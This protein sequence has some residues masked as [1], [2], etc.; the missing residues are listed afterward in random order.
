M[1]RHLLTLF[2]AAAALLVLAGCGALLLN[3]V[4]SEPR[5]VRVV[6]D[7]TKTVTVPEGM[8]WY[9]GPRKTQGLRFPAGRYPLEA[10]DA[11]Y[12]YFRSPSPLELRTFG[13]AGAAGTRHIAGG[14]MVA[15]GFSTVPGAA[16]EEGQ[17]S[18]KVMVWKLGQ[19]FLK[20][21]GRYWIKNF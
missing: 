7:P 21:K 20:L 12:W 6:V 2:V 8:A 5:S 17:G 3:P 11:D 16:Y 1:K 4:T 15:K 13:A 9:D 10:E 18:T 14:L 19:D